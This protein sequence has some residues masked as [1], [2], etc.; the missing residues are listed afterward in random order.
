MLHRRRSTSLI[1][2]TYVPVRSY[3][4]PMVIYRERRNDWRISVG[5]KAVNLRIPDAQVRVGEGDPVIWA[6]KWLNQKFDQ[7]PAIFY[8]LTQSAPSDGK[9]YD[10]LY[11]SYILSLQPVAGYRGAK[12]TITSGSI[13]ISHADYWTETDKREVFP[14]LISKV[15][16][17][18][19]R[20][21]FNLRVAE[22][23]QKHFGFAYRS[24]A[25]KYNTSNWGS[26]S[27]KGNLNF[28]S[29]L[30][31]APQVVTDY[32]IIHELAHLK[33]PN[34]S[35]SFWSVVAT[36]MPDYQQHITWLKEHGQHLYF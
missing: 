23:N 24:I 3:Q 20:P 13:S 14:K 31:L 10:T 25:L 35:R 19:L 34:H 29:R 33:V 27:T 2:K 1:T 30:F 8:H 12:A 5:K 26:C 6:T 21:H 28:S 11:G 22:L 9:R 17:A 4:V 18:R 16:C 32:V 7:D 15:L 36:A